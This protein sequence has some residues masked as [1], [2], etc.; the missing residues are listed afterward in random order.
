MRKKVLQQ[1]NEMGNWGTHHTLFGFD[2]SYSGFI[3]NEAVVVCRIS[4]FQSRLGT[5]IVCGKHYDKK[6][7]VTEV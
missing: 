2:L 4:Q 1:K 5:V 7:Q 3:L 6:A